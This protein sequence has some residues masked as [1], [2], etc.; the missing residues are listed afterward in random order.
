MAKRPV[1]LPAPESGLVGE[2]LVDFE[3]FPG[4][5]AVQKQRS[6]ESLHAAA[7]TDFGMNRLL[8]VS[9]KSLDH[10]GVRLSAFNLSVSLPGTERLILMEAAFQGSKVFSGQGPFPHLYEVSSGR[11]VRRFMKDLPP[12]QLIGFRYANDDWELTPKTAF[13]DWL[14]LTGVRQLAAEDDSIDESLGAYEAFTDIEFNPKKSINC[15]ARSCALYVSLSV[16]GI[17]HDALSDPG[18]FVE[19]LSSNGYGVEPDQGQLL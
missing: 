17:L 8:E 18:A 12:D 11:E 9:T 16:R 5:A 15:Q 1:F 13:Y 6:I 2:R 4:F 10:L 7:S 3:W 19:V 14:Y